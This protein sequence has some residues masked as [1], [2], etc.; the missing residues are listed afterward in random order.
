M[1]VCIFVGRFSINDMVNNIKIH[2]DLT[3]QFHFEIQIISF[4]FKSSL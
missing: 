3:K 4:L 2:T 1:P